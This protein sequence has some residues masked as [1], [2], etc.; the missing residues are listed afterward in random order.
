MKPLI[1]DHPKKEI[2]NACFRY[3]NGTKLLLIFLLLF[4]S[5]TSVISCD[6]F[7]LPSQCLS[8][9]AYTCV[10]H[11]RQINGIFCNSMYGRSWLVV[12]EI[13]TSFYCKLRTGNPRW[14]LSLIQTFLAIAI[15]VN[16]LI[17]KILPP[18]LVIE[19]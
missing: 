13:C 12:L 8:R 17:L 6:I 2:G 10:R 5:I 19:V 1:T 7:C 3:R 11:V 14:L 9:S 4:R 15:Y 18:Q 16:K